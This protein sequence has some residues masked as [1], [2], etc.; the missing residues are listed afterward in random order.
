MLKKWINRYW[1]YCVIVALCFIAITRYENYLKEHNEALMVLIT[2]VYLFATIKI[3]SANIESANAAREQMAVTQA[4]IDE[5]KKQYEETKHLQVLPVFKA[6]FLRK[7]DGC[8]QFFLPLVKTEAKT[9]VSTLIVLSNI[10]NGPAVNLSYKWK[11]ANAACEEPFG[12]SFVK[13]SEDIKMQIHFIGELQKDYYA[14]IL[15]IVYHDIFGEEY[16]QDLTISFDHDS[17]LPSACNLNTEYIKRVDIAKEDN[18][19]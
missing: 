12:I 8:Y 3:S 14:G 15:T 13:A 4:Q 19:A 11:Y 6:S 9:A 1:V 18:H 10:G 16:A 2:A 5:E 17:V 7:S